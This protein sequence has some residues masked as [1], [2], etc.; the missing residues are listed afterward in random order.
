MEPMA[1]QTIPKS[2][3]YEETKENEDK[4]AKKWKDDSSYSPQKAHMEISSKYG[5]E[6]KTVSDTSKP[7]WKSQSSCQLA[8]V[9]FLIFPSFHFFI[10][11]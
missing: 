1:G 2:S 11:Y 6:K 3:K 10:Y 7:W 4:E 8:I 9:D 5:G